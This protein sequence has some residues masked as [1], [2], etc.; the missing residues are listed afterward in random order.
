M[1]YP[2]RN[3]ILA[4]AAIAPAALLIGVL[5]PGLW[6]AGLALIA[7]LIAA[8]A[9]DALIGARAGEVEVNCEGPGIAGV[10]AEF[11]V[12]IFARFE[13]AS[14]ERCELAIDSHYLLEAPDGL[15]RGV[16][17]E[18][19]TAEAAVRLRALRRGSARID[20]VW[21][22]WR[23]LLGLVWKQKT[24]QLGQEIPVVPDI[25]QV[26]QKSAQLL[27]RDAMHG[28]VETRG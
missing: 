15:I 28:L 18:R 27:H 14:P 2:A 6:F 13:R 21:V 4:A 12:S 10:G 23:G 22:R 26:R 17:V 1:I 24:L 16:R 11:E 9:L 5:L 8:I 3:A 25:A 7:F 19:G 20:R